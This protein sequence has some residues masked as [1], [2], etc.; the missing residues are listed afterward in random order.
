ME[1]DGELE[2]ITLALKKVAGEYRITDL[3]WGKEWK[4]A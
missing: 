3:E 4:G 1:G 2:A